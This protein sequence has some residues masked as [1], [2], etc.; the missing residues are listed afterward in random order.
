MTMARE[1]VVWFDQR[2]DAK[3]PESIRRER[4]ARSTPGR[5]AVGV[6]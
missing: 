4:R 2:T 5:A 3:K 6:T 1:I